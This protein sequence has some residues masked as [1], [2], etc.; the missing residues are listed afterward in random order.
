MK[1]Y[2][3]NDTGHHFENALKFSDAPNSGL[4]FKFLSK[5]T[6]NVFQIDRVMKSFEKELEPFKKD[7]MLLL[8]GANVL[9]AIAVKILT[10]KFGY[11]NILIFD[12]RT[13]E[14]TKREL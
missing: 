11:F 3:V 1:I 4:A 14:Y 2:I 8:C 13:R 5:G 6:V 10:K 12:G 9:N 7:D